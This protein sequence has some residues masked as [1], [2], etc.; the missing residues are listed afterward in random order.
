MDHSLLVVTYYND[1]PNFR[2]FV[3]LLNKF[4]KSNKKIKIIYSL[5]T[6]NKE[7]L[8]E[9]MV[10]PFINK[11]IQDFLIDWDVTI[12]KGLETNLNGWHEQQLNKMYFSAED[13]QNYTIVFD[14]CNF[15]THELFF[16]NLFKNGKPILLPCDTNI[17]EHEECKKIF[18]INEPFIFPAS[19][20]PWVWKNFDIFNTQNFLFQKFNTYEHWEIYPGTEFLN[21]YCYKVHIEKDNDFYIIRKRKNGVL[22]HHRLRNI[23]HISQH[24]KK[25][26][27]LGI[28]DNEINFWK[29]NLVP[30]AFYKLP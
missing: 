11:C 4:W 14:C 13:N 27:E 1:L 20:T 22:Y 9:D 25:L 28:D 17:T 16:N 21:H 18:N 7:Y 15:L 30:Y 29:D 2:M 19:L 5:K 24:A 8:N 12:L 26:N 10:L 3:N 6:G 23:L